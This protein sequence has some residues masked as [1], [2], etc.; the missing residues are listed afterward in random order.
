VPAGLLTKDGA[1]RTWPQRDDT[2]GF[3]VAAFERRER[4]G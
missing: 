3:F 2:D 1:A 4:K